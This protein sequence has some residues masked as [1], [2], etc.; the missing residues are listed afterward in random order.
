[1]LSLS[2]S[3]HSLQHKVHTCQQTRLLTFQ[4]WPVKI[5]GS[6][7]IYWWNCFNDDSGPLCFFSRNHSIS[8][9]QSAAGIYVSGLTFTSA[10]PFLIRD[11]SFSRFTWDHCYLSSTRTLSSDRWPSGCVKN[12]RALFTLSRKVQFAHIEEKCTRQL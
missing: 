8:F 1:M 4:I 11:Q 10:A 5:K 3:D 6:H 7:Q 12:S 2:W 9:L